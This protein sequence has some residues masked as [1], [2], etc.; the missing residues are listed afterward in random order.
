MGASAEDRR[1]RPSRDTGI[2]AV[3]NRGSGPA[4]PGNVTFANIDFERE[5]LSDGL[6]RH[7]IALDE[8]GF[9]SWLGVTM[10]LTKDAIDAVLRSVPRKVPLPES[11]GGCPLI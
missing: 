10:Y 7:E 3:E 1:G 4:D 9:F 11:S 5:S 8:P 2:E 6:R